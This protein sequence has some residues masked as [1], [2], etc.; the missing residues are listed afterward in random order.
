VRVHFNKKAL[1][2]E[3]RCTIRL[4]A[5]GFKASRHKERG[6]H[7][8]REVHIPRRTPKPS[9]SGVGYCIRFFLCFSLL[10]FCMRSP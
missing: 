4:R 1:K 9:S 2:L 3:E 10:L 7:S 5:Q 8:L 6:V